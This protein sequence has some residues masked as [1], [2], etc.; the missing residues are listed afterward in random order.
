MGA[1]VGPHRWPL[2]WSSEAAQKQD[3]C[4]YYHDGKKSKTSPDGRCKY[5][6]AFKVGALRLASESRSTQ[7]TAQQLGIRPKLLRRWQQAQFVAE[8]S[9][10]EVARNP[11][12]RALRARLKRAEPE[13]D[14][15]KRSLGHLRPANAVSAYQHSAQRA[16]QAPVRQ[17]CHKP[18]LSGPTPARP[19]VVLLACGR[20]KTGE[21]LM[22]YDHPGYLRRARGC[23]QAHQVE[24]GRHLLHRQGGGARP[25]RTA[26]DDAAGGIEQLCNG[27][28]R[29]RWSVQPQYFVGR[30]GIEVQ[31]HALPWPRNV[32]HGLHRRI[33]HGAV[34][35]DLGQAVESGCR[36]RRGVGPSVITEG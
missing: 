13:S 9:G 29:P 11:E 2:R 19:A 15:L 16:G 36:T 8:V 23:L 14:V 4:S 12:V 32:G 1:H 5:D 7:A 34:G 26:P 22:R 18:W 35:I 27:R 17:L 31:P 30:V 20:E 28:R 24:P 25:G 6:D 10:V 3:V 33:R 21:V